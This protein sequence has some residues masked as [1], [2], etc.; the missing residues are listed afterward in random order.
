MKLIGLFVLLLNSLSLYAN[1]LAPEFKLKAS[2]GSI[3][4]LSDYKGKTVVLEWLNHG[5]PFV[6]KHYNSG[7]MQKTQKAVIDKNT[8]WLSIISSTEG[9]QGYSTP[10]QAEDDRKIFQSNATKILLDVDG[11]VGQAYEAKTTPHMFII[12]KRG[13]IVYQG[14]IDSI[15]STDIEDIKKA[16]PYIIEGI[17]EL[18]NQ[19]KLSHQKTKPYGCS[20]K[21]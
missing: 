14:A 8:V 16:T 12:N 4:K 3:V 5:C 15:A 11:S 6:K 21:Y 19:K 2:D 7:N 20:V 17:A 9:K 13:Y 10:T 1:D 18:K